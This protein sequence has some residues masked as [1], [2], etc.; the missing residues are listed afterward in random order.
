MLFRSSVT[1]FVTQLETVNTSVADM[2]LVTNSFVDNTKQMESIL[3]TISEIAEQTNLLSLNASIEAARAGEAGKGFAVVAGEIRNLADSSKSSAD[4]ISGIVKKIQEDAG[5]LNITMKECLVELE[6]GNELAK[7]TH[8]SFDT[9]QMGTNDI[10][11]KIKNITKSIESFSRMVEKTLVST[12]KIE[13]G[14][15][16]NV[17][18]INAMNEIVVVQKKNETEMTDAMQTLVL[19]ANELNEVVHYFTI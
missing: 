5:Q 12:E 3:L 1:D 14:S 16:N 13:S 4:T 17:S 2:S 15:L 9:I 11:D 8:Q 18:Q 19:I 6:K 10:G 7:D